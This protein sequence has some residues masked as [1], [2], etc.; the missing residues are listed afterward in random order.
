[1][2]RGVDVQAA[3][4][5]KVQAYIL[6]TWAGD[7]GASFGMMGQDP[8]VQ[9]GVVTGSPASP[10]SGAPVWSG[11]WPRASLG[12][13]VAEALTTLLEPHA[14]LLRS[15]R[16]GLGKRRRGWIPWLKS[17]LARPR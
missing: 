15:G 5:H 10:G 11:G 12:S 3:P 6:V 7:D 8:A 1:M 2:K 4:R 14:G 13:S 17:S 16:L 9:E